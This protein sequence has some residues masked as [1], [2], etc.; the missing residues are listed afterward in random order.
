MCFRVAC[1]THAIYN[2]LFEGG[3]VRTRIGTSTGLLRISLGRDGAV[4]LATRGQV[5]LALHELLGLAS[6]GHEKVRVELKQSRVRVRVG[7]RC[8]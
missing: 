8:C 5:G 2:L 6:F 7:W 1:E 4:A 3:T